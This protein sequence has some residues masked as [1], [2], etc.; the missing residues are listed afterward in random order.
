MVQFSLSPIL[1]PSLLRIFLRILESNLLASRSHWKHR[2]VERIV[3]SPASAT[4]STHPNTANSTGSNIHLSSIT[5][6][7]RPISGTSGGNA[8][9]NMSADGTNV[10]AQ[11]NSQLTVSDEECERL[12]SNMLLTQNATIVHM[13]LEYCLPTEIERNRESE[14]TV[15]RE[16]R[17]IICT[18]IHYM[19][20]AEPALAD[21]IVW[22]VRQSWSWQ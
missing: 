3:I 7:V 5:S 2:L 16:I 1:C 19:F 17:N 15:L 22:Q 4:A 6:G 12:C 9:E 8:A 14:V 13:L 10:T 20:I 21:V 11:G 18:Y